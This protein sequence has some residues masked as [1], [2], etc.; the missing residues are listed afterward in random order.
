MLQI[1]EVLRLVEH[2][3]YL[4]FFL[5]YMDLRELRQEVQKLPNVQQQVRQFELFWLKPLREHAPFG[6]SQ[7]LSKNE[8]NEL[9]RR[10]AKLQEPLQQLK[11][12]LQDELFY[13]S[14]NL[15]ELK[16]SIVQGHTLKAKS[17]AQR[18]MKDNVFNLHESIKKSKQ[19]KAHI[20]FLNTEYQHL[21][22]WIVARLPLEEK[23]RYDALPHKTHLRTLTQGVAKQEDVL[24]HLGKHF[25]T[26]MRSWK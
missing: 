16:L 26:L 6:F 2:F 17:T 4:Q 15:V 11:V 14:R 9:H 20:A 8:K 1:T 22:E 7:Y 10:L 24:Q 3:I 25:V 21:N 13:Y 12:P 18:L 19:L 23:L 5:N